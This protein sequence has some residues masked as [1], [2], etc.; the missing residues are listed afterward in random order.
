MP[1]LVP[2]LEAFLSGAKGCAQ[3][4]LFG[5]FGGR[6]HI[7]ADAQTIALCQEGFGSEID[8]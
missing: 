4:R 5:G 1:H 7:S 3:R 8:H 2:F 6:D